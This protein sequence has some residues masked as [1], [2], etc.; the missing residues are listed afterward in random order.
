MTWVHVEARVVVNEAMKAVTV[1][2]IEDEAL[3]EWTTLSSQEV[4]QLTKL[5]LNSIWPTC[6]FNSEAL[7]QVEGAAM[8]SHRYSS[9]SLHGGI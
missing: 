6:I 5:C 8:L 9:K 4:F 1:K 2:L 3:H 7:E